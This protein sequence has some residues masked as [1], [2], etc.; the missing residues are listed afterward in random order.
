ML[1]AVDAEASVSLVLSPAALPGYRGAHVSRAQARADLGRSLA[2]RATDLQ[3]TGAKRTG[4]SVRSEAFVFASPATAHS[5]AKSWR[6]VHHGKRVR[7]GSDASRSGTTVVWREGRK[8]GLLQVRG[9]RATASLALQ[10][11]HAADP[12]LRGPVP[13]GAWDKVTDKIRNDGSISK[14]A[15]LQAFSIAYGPV[16]GVTVPR[17]PPQTI[18]DGVV[19]AG[20]VTRYRNQLTAAQRAAVDRL[21]GN[22][23]PAKASAHAAVFT[24]DPNFIQD[25]ELQ[26]LA[27]SFV[28]VFEART[29]HKFRLE[30]LVGRTTTE[31][32]NTKAGGK[33]YADAIDL[34]RETLTGGKQQYACRIRKGPTPDQ[35]AYLDQAMAHEV[36]HCFQFDIAGAGMVGKPAWITEGMAEWAS[37]M[38][39][40]FTP[41]SLNEY[42]DTSGRALFSR[43]Y[44]GSGFWAHAEDMAPGLFKRLPAVLTEPDPVEAFQKAVAGGDFFS[45]WGSSVFRSLPNDPNWGMVSPPISKSNLAQHRPASMTDVTDSQVVYANPWTTAQYKVKTNNDTPLIHFAIE[46]YGRLDDKRN[47]TSLGDKW[48]CSLPQGCQCPP[49][50]IDT[51]PGHEPIDPDPLLGLSAGGGLTTGSVTYHTIDDFC[52]HKPSTGIG[53]TWTGSYQSSKY[54][55]VRGTF[56]VTFIVSKRNPSTFTGSIAIA[57][58]DCVTHGTLSGNISDNKITFGVLNA[59]K[60]IGYTGR[61]TRNSMSGAYTSPSCGRDAGSWEASRSG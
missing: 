18:I 34:F 32:G 1:V 16:P 55:R 9:K 38:V 25:A 49:G 20:W 46:R 61:I 48:F 57:G 5:V 23:D 30:L 44:D 21:L 7:L 39:Q 33:A 45:S 15:A 29:G 50:E 40:P 42:V 43:V 35:A 13:S 8:V 4:L 22:Q 28:P 52:R 53:G 56:R 37:L 11:A 51:V 54:S 41:Q 59:Q 19:A 17:G 6:T 58:S 14:Q 26:R 10:L 24:G 27:E 31:L 60:R 47:L 36:F 2:R 12:A 3:A